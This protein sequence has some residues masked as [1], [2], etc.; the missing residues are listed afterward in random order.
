MPG[1]DGTG[2]MGLGP[3]TGRGMGYCA[4]PAGQAPIGL[5]ASMAGW[6]YPVVVGTPAPVFGFRSGLYP[7]WRGAFLGRGRRAFRGF[8][9][10]GRC[11]GRGRRLW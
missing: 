7:A 6:R 9:M 8:G 1:F 4:V 10:R 3:L 5:P 11:G 2:P